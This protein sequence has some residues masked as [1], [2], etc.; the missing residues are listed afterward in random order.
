M[1]F[2]S[3]AYFW[4]CAASDFQGDPDARPAN[5][6]LCMLPYQKVLRI[7]AKGQSYHSLCNTACYSALGVGIYQGLIF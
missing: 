6:T 7:N 2:S 3:L 5:G 1:G 4:S